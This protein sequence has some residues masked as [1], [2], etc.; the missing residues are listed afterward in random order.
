MQKLVC[1][2][3]KSHEKARKVPQCA[4]IGWYMVHHGKKNV[5][6]EARSHVPC[7]WIDHGRGV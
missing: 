4:N 7:A 5:I 3:T 6:E 2:Q 1:A